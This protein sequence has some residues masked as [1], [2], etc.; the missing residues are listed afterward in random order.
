MRATY[1]YAEPGVI[2][3]D[4]I[5]AAEQP[6]LLRDDQRHQSVRPRRTWV[7]TRR[8]AAGARAGRPRVPAPGSMDR[9]TR[10]TRRLL[11]DGAQAGA[12]A[13]E[14]AEGY[15]LRLTADHRVRRVSALTRYREADWCCR[16]RTACRRPDRAQRSSRQARHGRAT[17]RRGGLSARP[18]GRRRHAEDGQG[19][20]QRLATSRGVNGTSARGIDGVMDEALRAAGTLPHRADFAGWANRG[21]ERVSPDRSRPQG[22]RRAP[23][24]GARA[25]RTITPAIE[26]TSSDFYMRLFAWPVRCATARCKAPRQRASSVR[27]AQ[28][29]LPRLRRCSACC[30]G[31]ASFPILY[32][33]AGLLV[34]AQLPDGKGSYADYPTQP[35]HELVITGDN[36]LQFRERVGFADP[37]EALPP[38]T[39]PSRNYRRAI[40]RERFVARVKAV[41]R[42]RRRGG[43]RRR[44]SRASTPSMPTA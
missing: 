26:R 33:I 14:T 27:L 36:L 35:Q 25:T 1:D 7:Q 22:A 39:W 12:S 19:G 17:S 13:C 21:P 44:E 30:C 31:S 3:I 38:S 11:P 20:D 23:R 34:L 42:G 8:A 10:R 5:N 40:N 24:H 43:L 41:V 29:D 37:D 28:T 32:R 4:R 16:R 9:I 6:R 18:A 2:F 15:T